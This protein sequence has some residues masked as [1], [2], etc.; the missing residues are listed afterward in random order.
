MFPLHLNIFINLGINLRYFVFQNW[1]WKHLSMTGWIKRNWCIVCSWIVCM[2]N[3]YHE[4]CPSYVIGSTGWSVETTLAENPNF[5]SKHL[6]QS[7]FFPALIY[8]TLVGL[9]TLEHIPYVPLN[10]DYIGFRVSG[11]NPNAV[12]YARYLHLIKD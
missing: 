6:Y 10:L 9:T 11:Q 7:V 3:V 2:Q 5:L 12:Y 4:S 8:L 1:K